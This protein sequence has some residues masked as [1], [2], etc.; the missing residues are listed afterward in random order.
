MIEFPEIPEN[1]QYGDRRSDYVPSKCTCEAP[2]PIQTNEYGNGEPATYKCIHC[3]EA[4]NGDTKDDPF[5]R[6]PGDLVSGDVLEARYRQKE[7]EELKYFVTLLPAVEQRRLKKLK[8][9]KWRIAARQAVLRMLKA[10]QQG[11]FDVKPHRRPV[12]LLQENN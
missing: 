9:E 12:R 4:L 6:W 1:R 8:G 11:S 3:G 5:R 7:P 10:K 2:T